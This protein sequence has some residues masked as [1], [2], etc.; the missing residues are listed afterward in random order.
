MK[1]LRQLRNY[2]SVSAA[3]LVTLAVYASLR[4]TSLA[5]SP[6]VPVAVIVVIWLLVDNYLLRATLTGVT[7][8]LAAAT[9]L[10]GSGSIGLVGI[11]PFVM[12]G[13]DA[14]V[15]GAAAA[16]DPIIRPRWYQLL[17]AG[18]FASV[19]TFVLSFAVTLLFI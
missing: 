9:S 8:G 14:Y 5:V 16:F 1:R 10:S 6:Y 4:L 3:V 12:G 11:F 15:L 18:G 2:I 19:A 17:G 13:I 7:Y